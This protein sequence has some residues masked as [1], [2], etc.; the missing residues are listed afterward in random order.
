MR[1]NAIKR[2]LFTMSGLFSLQ[3]MAT[4]QLPS[5]LILMDELPTAQRV[6]VYEQ[7][8]KFLNQHPKLAV[9]AKIIAVDGKG[10]IYVLDEKKVLLASG[11]NPSVI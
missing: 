6:Q 4:G 11:G 5:D 10:T 1:K 9:D 2:I 7:V 8:L 3:A